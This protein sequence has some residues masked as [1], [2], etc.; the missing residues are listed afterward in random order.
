[1]VTDRLGAQTAFAAGHV[2]VTTVAGRK[3]EAD[4]QPN[5]G[6]QPIPFGILVAL[7]D[8]SSFVTSRHPRRDTTSLGEQTTNDARPRPS[9]LLIPT[10]RDSRPRLG[11]EP[12]RDTGDHRG[13][14]GGAAS[15]GDIARSDTATEASSQGF[16]GRSRGIRSPGTR[17]PHQ[18]AEQAYRPYR[19][20]AGVPGGTP[21]GYWSCI[22]ARKVGTLAAQ[23]VHVYV[24][25]WGYPAISAR[26]G[27]DRSANKPV[28]IYVGIYVSPGRVGYFPCTFMWGFCFPS[29]GGV[30]GTHPTC[31]FISPQYAG[32]AGSVGRCG[33]DPHAQQLRDAW[34][35]SHVPRQPEEHGAQQTV[36]HVGHL[37]PAILGQQHSEDHIGILHG[38]R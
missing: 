13:R 20:T 30:G 19:V 28:P 14:R 23:P 24:G 9:R 5:G 16:P 34:D 37:A 38:V 1:M 32:G 12:R 17:P 22:S 21:L 31:G 7:T 18:G 36:A 2:T 15:D 29:L 26:R 8:R 6:T 4:A 3:F 11:V 27:G 33:A 35:P 25:K 10:A